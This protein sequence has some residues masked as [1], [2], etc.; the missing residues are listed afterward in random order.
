MVSANCAVVDNDIPGPE[1]DGVPL[2]SL[3]KSGAEQ[4]SRSLLTFFTSNFFFPSI[5]LP[6]VSPFDPAGASAISTSAI[7]YAIKVSG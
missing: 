4:T 5:A 7:G 6:A 1:C 3:A 2:V